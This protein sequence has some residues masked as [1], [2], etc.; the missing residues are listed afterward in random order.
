MLRE[1]IVQTLCINCLTPRNRV[2]P[3]KATGL[4]LLKNFPEFYGTRRFITAF[5]N[6]PHLSLSWAILIHSI[7]LRRDP[8]NF[9]LPP[10]PRSGVWSLSLSSPHENSTCISPV[11]HLCHSL[12]KKLFR[13]KSGLGINKLQ[14]NISSNKCTDLGIVY[15]CIGLSKVV[16]LK[17]KTGEKWKKKHCAVFY[18]HVT[19]H[20]NK[21]IYNKT[22]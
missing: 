2:L 9:L 21:F 17:V 14:G 16:R 6:A 5:I 4:Q 12:F 20:R 22:Y 15:I 10:T 1:T 3:E 18:V 7:P 13:R 11:S 19:V 8:F